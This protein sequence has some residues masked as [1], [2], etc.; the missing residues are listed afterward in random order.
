M[1]PQTEKEKM[2]TGQLYTF[3][4]PALTQEREEAKIR[5]R[6]FNQAVTAAD[7]YEALL[8][9]LG[10]LGPNAII[11]PPF[12]CTYGRNI[13]LGANSYLNFSCTILDNAP[14]RIGAGVMIGPN[15]QFYTAAHPLQPEPRL[16]GW[17]TAKAITVED[18]V[19]IGGGAIILPGV[20]IG[21]YAVVGAGAVVTKNV[22]PYA[23]VGGNPAKFIKEI[24]R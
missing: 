5:L 9:L 17:E 8:D 21:H 11:E 3:F 23:V 20:T 7:T 1:P 6:R 10:S 12:F 15:A 19:W 18:G 16:Q 13:Y 2:L 4:D 24:E 14:V 22:Q